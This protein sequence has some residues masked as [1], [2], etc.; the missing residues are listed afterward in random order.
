MFN[1]II[2]IY[3]FFKDISKLIFRHL[4]ISTL[5]ATTDFLIF[6][7]IFYYFNQTVQIAYSISFISATLV[8]FCG[9]TFFTYSINK[10]YWRNILFF[11][12]QASIAFIIGYYLILI[13]IS[14]GIHVLLSKIL[15][16]SIVFFFNVFVGKLITFKKR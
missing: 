6:S 7:L 12:I 3:I 5:C 4:I 10:F 16:L 13:L 14:A 9:H 15:Q 2:H 1:H 8:G 11:C